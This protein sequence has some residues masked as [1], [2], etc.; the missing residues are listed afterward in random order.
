MRDAAEGPL[1]GRDAEL[2]QIEALA[3]SAAMGQGATVLISGEGGIGKTRLVDHALAAAT[4]LG[5]T[6][7]FARAVEFDVRR[8]FHAIASALGIAPD[9]ADPQRRELALLLAGGQA[10]QTEPR[11]VEAMVAIVERLCANGP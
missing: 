8:P 11:L 6:T 7:R 5:M 1:F 3:M 4:Q 2:R 10:H 9:A